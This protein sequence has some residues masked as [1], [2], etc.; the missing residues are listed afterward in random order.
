[1]WLNNSVSC[2]EFS[3]FIFSTVIKLILV[4]LKVG[5]EEG[6]DMKRGVDATPS[7]PALLHSV[8]NTL[9]YMF[10]PC[11]TQEYISTHLCTVQYTAIDCNVLLHSV[12][13]C[14]IYQCSA[15]QYAAIDCNALLHC[16][17]HCNMFQCTSALCNTLY[18]ISMYFCTVFNILRCTAIHFC[19]VCNTLQHI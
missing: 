11:N 15:M 13:H 9:Q 10:A 19:A 16:A 1:M 5:H 7:E 2:T 8:C 12:I 6:R 18:Y 4:S 17:I 3:W 14:N